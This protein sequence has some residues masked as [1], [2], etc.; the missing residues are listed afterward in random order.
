VLY[1]KRALSGRL[2]VNRPVVSL[3]ALSEKTGLYRSVR[4][5]RTL[6][7][8]LTNDELRVG[9]ETVLKPLSA[10]TFT[11][12]EGG[13]RVEFETDASGRVLRLHFDTVTDEG[14][15]YEKVDPAH[16]S[17]ADLEA[18]MG[19]YA[20]DEAETA[21]RVTLDGNQLVMLQ[22]PD[23]RIPLVPTYQDGFSSS[24]R[25]RRFL[26]DG[27]GRVTELSIGSERLWDIRFHRVSAPRP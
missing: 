4:D 20:S 23:H 18:M 24:L 17:L 11:A 1:L 5:H 14:N 9:G 3:A 26:R 2:E 12:S 8:E 15:V 10:N 6:S 27:T 7:V 19:E 13:R 25:S 16:P 21:L 22:K